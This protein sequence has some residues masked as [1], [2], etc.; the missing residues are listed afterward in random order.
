MNACCYN[1]PTGDFSSK[2]RNAPRDNNTGYLAGHIVNSHQALFHSLH[3]HPFSPTRCSKPTI[4]EVN[5]GQMCTRRTSA[6]MRIP[7]SAVMSTHLNSVYMTITYHTEPPTVMES[8]W[9]NYLPKCLSFVSAS[10]TSMACCLC[11]RATSSG[12]DHMRNVPMWGAPTLLPRDDLL[13]SSVRTEAPATPTAPLQLFPPTRPLRRLPRLLDSVE[14]ELVRHSN[15]WDQHFGRAFVLKT[16][17]LRLS[18]TTADTLVPSLSFGTSCLPAHLEFSPSR[19]PQAI[20][21]SS[22]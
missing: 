11:N 12:T 4:Q 22:G 14:V 8:S 3:P 17:Q 13:R 20:F 18:T 1:L 16:Y 10:S 5:M 2:L 21:K 6:C 15:L 19:P 7:V 9:A